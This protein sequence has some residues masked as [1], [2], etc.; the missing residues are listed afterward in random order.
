MP[1]PDASGSRAA[2]RMAWGGALVFLASLLAERYAYLL[3][4]DLPA[5]GTP[6]RMRLA[7]GGARVFLASLL[8]GAYGCLF[9]F[10]SQAVGSSLLVPVTWNACLFSLFALH[11]SLL[12]RSG[13]K[14]WIRQLVGGALE[15]ST[16]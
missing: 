16:Y 9:R 1:A 13:A 4:L 14:A 5:G 8:A 15:R 6:G 10:D 11:H 2:M 12:A 7:R 3:P